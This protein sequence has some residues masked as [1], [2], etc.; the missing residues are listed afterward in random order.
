MLFVFKIIGNIGDD[1]KV[2]ATIVALKPVSYTHLITLVVN[3]QNVNIAPGIVNA[4]AGSEEV[5]RQSKAGEAG[6]YKGKFNLYEYLSS[7][8]A[9]SYTHLNHIVIGCRIHTGHTELKFLAAPHPVIDGAGFLR[10][11]LRN[12]HM[13]PIFQS[14]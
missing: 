13:P 14:V 5:K 12:L 6:T 10:P 9:V 8:I 1:P 7:S 3:N 2:H 11:I 4:V